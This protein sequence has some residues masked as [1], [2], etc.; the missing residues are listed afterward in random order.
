MG[1]VRC[2]I[3]YVKEGVWEQLQSL[4]SLYKNIKNI[5]LAKTTLAVETNVK[6]PSIFI[7]AVKHVSKVNITG[8]SYFLI[9]LIQ[10]KIQYFVKNGRCV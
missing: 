6:K 9:I 2:S 7:N 3:K 10:P 5:L 1:L 8:A 4:I